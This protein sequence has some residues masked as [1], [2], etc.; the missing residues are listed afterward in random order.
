[1][2]TILQEK[3][4]GR[5]AMGRPRKQNLD[6]I[7]GETVLRRHTCFKEKPIGREVRIWPPTNFMIEEEEEEENTILLQ[8]LYFHRKQLV[9]QAPNALR[10]GHQYLPLRAIGKFITI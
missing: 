8:Q 7:A 5:I 2:T 3:I 10:R 9:P 4:N 6:Q 1:M